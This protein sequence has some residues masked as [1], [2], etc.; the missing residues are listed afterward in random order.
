M[1]IIPFLFSLFFFLLSL[2]F[3]TLFVTEIFSSS[4]LL[5]FIQA[6]I[7][8]DKA[9]SNSLAAA[10]AEEHVFP[11]GSNWDA[12]QLK[13]LNFPLQP[14]TRPFGDLHWEH[15]LS[16][17]S[18]DI[19][20]QLRQGFGFHQDEWIRGPVDGAYK[21]F[22][23]YLARMLPRVKEKQPTPRK[24]AVRSNTNLPS[25]SDH[26][27]SSPLPVR[28]IK[29]PPSSSD[30]NG[31]SIHVSSIENLRNSD[32]D[33]VRSDSDVEIPHTPTPAPKRRQEH[34]TK[35]PSL[36]ARIPTPISGSTTAPF[37][38]MGFTSSQTDSTIQSAEHASSVSDD[39]ESEGDRP[40][41]EVTALIRSLL[42][43][44]CE[45]HGNRN[46]Y[47]FSVDN[48]VQTLVIPI[49]GD[50][51]KTIP[52]MIVRM[53]QGKKT[54]SIVDYEVCILCALAWLNSS[55]KLYFSSRASD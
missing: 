24:P 46:G 22:Y 17:E 45:A 47:S 20:N 54:Y 29:R 38:A 5:S 49:C 11:S 1:E 30:G 18:R 15:D 50:F 9:S 10:M 51:P 53:H 14:E 21:D 37:I 32:S 55:T 3:F 16:N 27:S 52:D 34:F 36:P 26:H 28:G 31:P 8:L 44:I 13:R 25:S 23:D 12:L 39:E 2:F 19:L 48:D 43:R 33:E 42:N 4:H 40:E 35:S 6:N 41:T 7:A